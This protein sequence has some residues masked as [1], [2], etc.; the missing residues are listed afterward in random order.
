MKI[1]LASNSKTRKKILDSLNIK[2]DVIVSDK[3]EVADNSDPRKYVEELS[4]VKAKSVSEKIDRSDVIIIAADSIIYKDGKIYQKPKSIE[5]AMENLREFS[6][7]KNQG[8]TGVTIIDMSNRRNVT[9]SCVTDVYFKRICEEDIKW[10][11]KH[12]KDLL[13][14]AGYS[15]E[16]TISLFVEKIEGDFYNVLGLPLGMLYTKLNELGYSLNDFEC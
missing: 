11:V 14:K 15:L 10:Y 1:I 8:I 16:G 5:E 3:E 7:C 9:F 4:K 12:E 2:Y 13:K 6:N